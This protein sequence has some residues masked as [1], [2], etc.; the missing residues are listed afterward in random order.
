MDTNTSSAPGKSVLTGW[1][2]GMIWKS[3]KG[4]HWSMLGYPD[5]SP[6][7][8][9]TKHS[10]FWLM[11]LASEVRKQKAAPGCEG[12]MTITLMN[13]SSSA[14]H[15][16]P[17]FWNRG[18]GFAPRDRWGPNGHG[19][20][21]THVQSNINHFTPVFHHLSFKALVGKLGNGILFTQWD[22]SV[23]EEG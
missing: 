21:Q 7:S 8:K 13:L 3:H 10:Q 19:T 23:E 20:L 18:V 16:S 12:E 22:S 5:K 2:R 15:V 11:S 17:Y 4:K 6:R 9:V 1:W 14:L